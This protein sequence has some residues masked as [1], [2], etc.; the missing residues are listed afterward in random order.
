M[1]Q[2]KV[3]ILVFAILG[4]VSLFIPM[5]GFSFFTFLKMMG[6]GYLVPILGGFVLAAVAG[7]L[8]VAK[9][10]AQAWQAPAAVAGFALVFVRF[11]M[12]QIGD[13]LKGPL[14]AKLLVVSV[15]GGLIVSIIGL[16]KK[17]ET[18]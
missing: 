5:E 12:W 15:F 11:K 18:A 8:A 7:G 13:I 2:M 17:E 14:P 3:L 4:I 6:M 9:P 10:P 16:V 1:K